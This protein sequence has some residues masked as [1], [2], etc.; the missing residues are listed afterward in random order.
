MED[1]GIKVSK[2]GYDVRTCSDDQLVMS[3][4]FNLLKTKAT[5]VKTPAGDIAHGLSYVPIFFTTRPF[6]T[7]GGHYS[8]IG[9][10]FSTCDA[11][12][13]TTLADNTR[14]YIFYQQGA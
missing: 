1:Y 6:A 8:L 7:S 11:T 9:D 10:D 12:N 5:G 2:E 4:T 13:L 14:Y 3:S